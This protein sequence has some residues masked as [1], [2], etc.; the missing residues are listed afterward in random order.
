MQKSL[1]NTSKKRVRLIKTS[2]IIAV[3]LVLFIITTMLSVK[4]TKN[5][6]SILLTQLKPN[7]SKQMMGYI[8]ETSDNKTVVIDG[9]TE[10]DAENLINWI[11]KQGGKVDAW[12]ITHPHIDHIGAFMNIV[13]NTEIPI[14]NIYLSINELDWYKQYEPSRINEIEKFFNILNN[15]RISQN[16]HEAT[17][18]QNIEIDNIRFEILGVKNP[19]IIQ[20]AV[21][22][23]SMVIKMYVSNKTVL[24]LGDTGEESGE[25]LLKEQGENLKSD[26]VQMAHHGQNGVTE[27]V[28]KVINPSICLWPTP[29]WL[30]N[31]DSGGGEDSGPW[32]TKITRSWMSKLNVKQNIIESDVDQTI[33]IP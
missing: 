16:I 25:K 28:Y 30:W 13:E 12:F 8:L 33:Q 19:E 7:S 27:D 10:E 14:E 9:G 1:V 32:K 22:N 23:S 20:N 26:I 24:F 2:L 3:L 21:N 29:E 6:E 15:S 5:N 17:L 4:Y 18:G 31:N 11:N